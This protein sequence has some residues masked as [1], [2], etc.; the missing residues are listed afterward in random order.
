MHYCSFVVVAFSM[1][2]LLF[3]VVSLLYVAMVV[4]VSLLLPV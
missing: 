4:V 2:I 1:R 3:A